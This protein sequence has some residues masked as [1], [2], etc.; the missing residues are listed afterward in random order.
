M[1]RFLWTY[2]LGLM[3]I[4]VTVTLGQLNESEK[5]ALLG[6]IQVMGHGYH[7]SEEWAEVGNELTRLRTEAERA[8]QL[9]T[10]IEMNVIEAMM[11]SDQQ[12]DVAGAIALL[13]QTKK[14]YFGRDVGNMK[15]VY[16]L[17]SELYAR[18]GNELVI[19]QLIEEFKKS[20]YFD[21]D[22]YPYSGGQGRDVPLRVTRPRA[23]G[24][25][26]VT[27]STMERYRTLSR[28]A[29][30]R[31][32]PDVEGVNVQGQRVRLSDYRGRV[33]LVDFWLPESTLWSRDLPTLLTTYRHY[34]PAGFEIIGVYLGRDREAASQLI[35]DQGM[36]WEQW[37]VDRRTLGQLGIFGT[38]LNF[39]VDRNGTIIARDLRGANLVEAIRLS[40]AP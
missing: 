3:L 26:S 12:R 20:P 40:V 6:R 27:V 29:P 19:G 36:S 9:D 14:T 35:R 11:K 18:L 37:N 15:R 8:G 21:P 24:R 38:A 30:G 2:S 28:L 39:L 17:L 1:N 22:N 32:S 7:T 33:V 25:D 31:M 10:V 13:E 16:V 23:S 5:L 4:F 34:K